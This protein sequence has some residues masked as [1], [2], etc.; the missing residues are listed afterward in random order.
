MKYKE[1]NQEYQMNLD[2]LANMMEKYNSPSATEEEKAEIILF[3]LDLLDGFMKNRCAA[4]KN[5]N[6]TY[7]DMMSACKLAVLESLP[8]YDPYYNGGSRPLTYFGDRILHAVQTAYNPEALTGHFSNIVRKMKKTAAKY[9]IPFDEDNLSKLAKIAD[10]P[11]AS[12]KEALKRSQYTVE[13]YNPEV[14]DLS[15]DLHSPERAYEEQEKRE[16]IQ[17]AVDTLPPVERYV[18][19]GLIVQEL[20]M[21]EMIEYMMR[22]KEKL[23]LSGVI[24]KRRI[25]SIKRTAL[26]KLEYLLREQ[27][28]G[29]VSVIKPNFARS[30]KELEIEVNDI[31]AA[32]DEEFMN[33]VPD[34][35][36]LVRL[37]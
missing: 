3:F 24:D 19:N 11:Y 9:N 31:E 36:L 22:D 25:N 21:T 6:E 34:S 29:R 20:D 12:A 32:L 15:E 26:A 30:D 28:F 14:A 33:A 16:M 5:N 7:E 35:N 13:E 8:G 18:V 2:E 17:S 37:D 10:I 1:Q 4:F 23:G 27:G